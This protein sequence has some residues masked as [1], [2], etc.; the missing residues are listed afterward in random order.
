[1]YQ[2]ITLQS[3]LPLGVVISFFINAQVYLCLAGLYGMLGS[4]LND[5]VVIHCCSV[6]FL[7][8]VMF[9]SLS[10]MLPVL[11]G[12]RLSYPKI[13]S[14][15][16]LISVNLGLIGFCVGLVWNLAFGFIVAF[17][18]LTLGIGVFISSIFVKI[19]QIKHF[20]PSLWYMVCALI[21]LVFVLVFGGIMLMVYAGFFGVESFSALRLAHIGFG[22]FGWILCLIIGVCLQVLPMFYVAPMFSKGFYKYFIPSLYVALFL[23]LCG[24]F[25]G[26][27]AD[28][29]I[30]LFGIISFAF[31][32]QA[33]ILLKNRRRKIFDGVMLLWFFG[34]SHF[35][36]F[37]LLCIMSVILESLGIVIIRAN[38]LAVVFGFG[39]FSIVYAMLFKIVPFLAWFHLSYASM[40]DIQVQLPNMNEILKPNQIWIFLAVFV[41]FD[42]SLLLQVLMEW[43]FMGIIS[44]FIA[45]CCGIMM[46]L[47]ISRA[48]RIYRNKGRILPI[49]SKKSLG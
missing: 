23:G 33:M 27:R 38:S 48:Y 45:F 9:G 17:V 40:Q 43:E 24:V 18:C 19:F 32:F 6:G 5:V 31:G 16:T 28:F 8:L 49:Y 41:I 11:G 30:A 2:G 14:A 15:I 10:Q 35:I 46:I 21:S 36:I 42:A 13:I 3:A 22:A 12:V 1:M 25:F 26:F 44:G 47:L 7:L 4:G 29:V 34:F 20:T 37:G 39:V